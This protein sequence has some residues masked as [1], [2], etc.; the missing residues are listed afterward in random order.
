VL[1]HVLEHVIDPV[2]VLKLARAWLAPGGRV[3]AAVPNARSVHRQAAVIMGLLPVE[4]AMS[5]ADIHH[6]HR[7]IFNPETFRQVFVES[8]MEIEMFGGFW[9]KPVSNNQIEHTWTPAMLEAF[10]KIGERYPDIAA[11]IYIV[12]RNPEQL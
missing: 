11:E 8:G 9:L 4:D 3:L 6:G 7:R 10:M 5:E 2:A 12:A 1:G